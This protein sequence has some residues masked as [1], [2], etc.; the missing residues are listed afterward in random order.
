MAHNSSY[1]GVMDEMDWSEM[2]RLLDE[3]S[4]KARFLVACRNGNLAV[5]QGA[6]HVHR[7]YETA[8]R[9][10]C[11]CGHV[12]QLDPTPGAWPVDCMRTMQGVV[13]IPGCVDAQCGGPELILF[14]T[15]THAIP[16]DGR[17]GPICSCMR[18]G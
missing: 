6:G 1:E 4:S 9:I 13:Y 15:T 3:W 8:F 18:D 16:R 5:V 14:A 12:H 17:K 11:E 10:A 2:Q 7:S